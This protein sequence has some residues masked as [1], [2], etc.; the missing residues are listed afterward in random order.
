M[1]VTSHAAQPFPHGIP[2]LM[3]NS[4]MH[5]MLS[6]FVVSDQ[7]A[8]MAASVCDHFWSLAAGG[9]INSKHYAMLQCLSP[10][11]VRF[12]HVSAILVKLTIVVGALVTGSHRLDL[13]IAEPAFIHLQQPGVFSVRT[14]SK[15]L[16]SLEQNFCNAKT[17]CAV[18]QV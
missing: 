15:K 10:S 13:I 4:S 18:L 12:A 9:T 5:L 6:I 17:C 14:R 8:A 3:R 1:H 11:K 2:F 7:C 16:P